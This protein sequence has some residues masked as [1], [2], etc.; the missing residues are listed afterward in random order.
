MLLN[1]LASGVLLVVVAE[2]FYVGYVAWERDDLPDAHLALAEG[3]GPWRDVE[4][5]A[6]HLGRAMRLPV[7][8]LAASIVSLVFYRHQAGLMLAIMSLLVLV[9][10][11]FMFGWLVR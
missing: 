2:L 1:T 8:A 7:L 9:M 6:S 11:N 10:V 5:M 3:P 4:P